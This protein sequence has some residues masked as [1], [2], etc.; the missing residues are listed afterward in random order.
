MRTLN[1]FENKKQ[2]L[3]FKNGK[4]VKTA[5]SRKKR[6]R[7]EVKSIR[8]FAGDLKIFT[9]KEGF[10]IDTSII[11]LISLIKL[12]NEFKKHTLTE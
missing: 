12:K 1:Y 2:Y 7:T 3:I 5:C 11:N 8:E 9:N 10:L 6:N 4:L